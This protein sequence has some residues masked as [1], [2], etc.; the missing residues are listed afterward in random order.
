MIQNPS[1][2]RKT[3]RPDL[4]AFVADDLGSIWEHL[5]P[6]HAQRVVQWIDRRRTHP[7]EALEI[8]QRVVAEQTE[9]SS[10]DAAWRL[11]GM[12]AHSHT[13]LGQVGNAMLALERVVDRQ[14]GTVRCEIEL[15]RLALLCGAHRTAL[16]WFDRAT[17]KALM[18]AEGREEDVADLRGSRLAYSGAAIANVMLFRVDDAVPAYRKV[19]G[20]QDPL[21]QDREGEE[22]D[23]PELATW[24]IS[25]GL[26]AHCLE[27]RRN[28]NGESW[29]DSDE[30]IDF[31]PTA[32]EI[33]PNGLR[34]VAREAL[35]FRAAYTWNR[36]QVIRHLEPLRRDYFDAGIPLRRL[37]LVKLWIGKRWPELAPQLDHD[38]LEDYFRDDT[39]GYVV[40]RESSEWPHPDDHHRSDYR[41]RM[42]E[43]SSAPA[44]V[45]EELD[46]NWRLTC[47][48]LHFNPPRRPESADKT[49]DVDAPVKGETACAS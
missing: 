5:S 4:P 25:A 46:E 7:D 27:L 20:F 45:I 35:V 49:T 14:P 21:G 2:D 17:T 24:V 19:Q 38:F 30:M 23:D 32:L 9:E 39:L 3:D 13:R 42:R 18:T 48:L 6:D 26:L 12:L 37:D 11:A 34:Y 33:A 15:G 36:E 1:E 28:R 10:D 22:Y 16:R 8:V 31:V 43:C 40:W 47:T 29:D 41:R 44:E